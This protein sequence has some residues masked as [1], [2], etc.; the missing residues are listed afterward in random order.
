MDQSYSKNSLV[1]DALLI[2]IR[3]VLLIGIFLSLVLYAY[4]WKALKH[5]P[6]KVPA[7]G[8]ELIVAPGTT[9]N[10]FTKQLHKSGLLSHPLLLRGY[11]IYKGNTRLIKAGEYRVEQGTTPLQL[12]DKIFKG[13]VTQ[14]SFTIIEGWQTSQ[15]I[16]ALQQH[17]KIKATLTGL[18]K[19]QVIEKLD[20]PVQ[21]LEGIFLPDT[22][23]FPANTTDV[24]FMRRA[25]FSLQLKL[26]QAWEQRDPAC[27][28]NSPYEALILASIIEKETSLKTEYAQISGVFTRRLIKKM[29]LQ[30]DPTVIYALQAQL[31]GPLLRKHLQIDSPYNTYKKVGLPPTPIALPSAMAIE[32][33]L[34]PAVGDALYFVATGDGG[35]IFNASLEE[36]NK[37]VKQ[38]YRTRTSQSP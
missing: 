28:L 32:A 17:P 26:Q 4:T 37:A 34:H 29:K 38:L 15:V 25:F 27:A 36:H 1:R 23:S 11:L 5:N 16:A 31:N 22:Y 30:A 7:G 33:A 20:I 8:Y 12:L 18:S 19:A 9:L 14:Y 35:H 2:V 24:E 6:L 10:Q 3:Y 13:E 21:H